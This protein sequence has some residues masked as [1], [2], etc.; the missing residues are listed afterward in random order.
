MKMKIE[1]LA[2]GLIFIKSL[3]LSF[4]YIYNSKTGPIVPIILLFSP[5]S[6]TSVDLEEV[7]PGKRKEKELRTG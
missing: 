2:F 7:N 3:L 6:S 5:D 4:E 1:D